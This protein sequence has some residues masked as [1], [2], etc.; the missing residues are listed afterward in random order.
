M[1]PILKNEIRLDLILK[2]LKDKWKTYFLIMFT[3]A[4]VSSLLVICIPRYYVTSVKLAPEYDDQG[5]MSGALGGAASLLGVNMNG[6]FGSDAIVPEFYPDII[7]STDFLVPI[8]Y[9]PV[10]THNGE[11]E[12]TYVEYILTQEKY[13]W[14]SIAFSKVKKFISPKKEPYNNSKDYRANPYALTRSEYDILQKISSVIDCSVDEKTGVITLAVTTQDPLVAAIMT[15]S[16]KAHLQKFI[17]KY[18][19]EKISCE[20]LHSTKLSDEAYSKY[21]VAQEQYADFVD[22]HQNLTRQIHKV[23]QERL[24]SEAQ[25]ALS[26]YTTLYQQKL[27]TEAELQKK[28]PAFTILQNPTVPVKPAGPKRM[29][30]VAVMAILSALVYTVILIAKNDMKN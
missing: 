13:P 26:M 19:I 3:T 11:F 10:K 17:T 7:K 9:I 12:G 20:L 8:M 4:V 23:E 18:K 15:D 22:K 21:L 24:A 25:M 29:I 1:E 14:W 28:T 2:I 30:I 16:V 27:F 6:M 5:G